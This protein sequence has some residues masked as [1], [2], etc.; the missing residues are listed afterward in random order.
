MPDP[1]SGHGL[2]TSIEHRAFYPYRKNPFSV[3]TLFGENARLAS[4]PPIG[5]TAERS[6]RAEPQ[7]WI[8]RY[9]YGFVLIYR[10]STQVEVQYLY[11]PFNQSS[12]FAGSLGG[13]AV[14]VAI[15]TAGASLAQG[16]SQ[17]W[18]TNLCRNHFILK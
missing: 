7:Q 12:F 6:R 18:A 5:H 17:G 14:N 16:A 10:S 3:A 11:V 8:L 1:Y 4:W 9:S 2:N 13:V 15:F